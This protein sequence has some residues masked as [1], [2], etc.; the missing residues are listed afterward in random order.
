MKLE[1]LIRSLER[2]RAAVMRRPVRVIAAS[3]GRL[4]NRWMKRSFVFRQKAVLRLVRQAGYEEKMAHAQLDSL[5]SELS[6][7]R[8]MALL[9]SEL[10][11]SRALDGFVRMTGTG[12]WRWASGPGILFHVFAGN[13]PNP[14]VWSFVFGMLLKSANLGKVSGRNPGIL[15]LYLDSLAEED[16]RLAACNALISS[17]SDAALAASRSDAV[18]AYGTEV[19]LEAIRAHVPARV[20]FFAYG[21][22]FS[23]GV[24]TRGGILSGGLERLAR[25][26][27]EDVW[28][29]DQKGCLSPLVYF[30]Y[31]GDR[32]RFGGALADALS[33]LSK[34][35]AKAPS[36]S[37]K[38][39]II[40]EEL[41]GARSQTLTGGAWTVVLTRE[42]AGF[43]NL[44]EY[45]VTVVPFRRLSELARAL[46]AFK[47]YLQCVSLGVSGREHQAV[48][49]ELSGLGINRFCSPGRMQRP[50]L[51]WPHDGHFNVLPLV[52]W[53]EIE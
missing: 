53:S 39:R 49:K 21:P 11:D 27:A 7:K 16:A 19:S 32:G 17:R 2:A 6:E 38:N 15:D 14:A 40:L 36:W 31:G 50:P 3:L 22:K 13:V 43:R 20:P 9:R 46:S 25:L 42:W 23:F 4:S 44:P 33:T 48:A 18:I 41:K 47:G 37:L 26:C 24:V 35:K 12:R 1:S 34:R 29:A 8:L 28:M 30:V 10:G 5:F 51:F 45:S 52:E